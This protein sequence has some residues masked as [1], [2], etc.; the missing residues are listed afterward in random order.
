MMEVADQSTFSMSTK[1]FAFNEAF[2]SL[3]LFND[4]IFA[5]SWNE[6][7]IPKTFPSMEHYSLF[8]ISVGE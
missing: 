1:R 6:A 5:G 7:F 8:M 2:F 3:L 4:N